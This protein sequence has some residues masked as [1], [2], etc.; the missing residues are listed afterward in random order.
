M[1]YLKNIKWEIVALTMPRVKR[2]CP[3]CGNDASFKNSQKFRVNANKNKLDVWLIYQCEKCKSTWNM[4]I[5][6]RVSC[7]DI[8]STQY[9]LFLNNDLELA[10]EYGFDIA[11]HN[12]N[13]VKLEFE[14]VEYEIIGEDINILQSDFNK[15]NKIVVDIRCKY[16]LGLR[17][18]KVLSKKLGVSRGKVKKLYENSIICEASQKDL[19]KEKINDKIR[20]YIG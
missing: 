7:I 8:D 9:E 20:I 13:K 1:S 16:S 6:E 3:K 10:K 19:L 5:Y 12:K 18:D 2:N 15:K 14:N 11:I 17:V 4:A